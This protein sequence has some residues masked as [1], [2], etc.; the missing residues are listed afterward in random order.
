MATISIK[1]LIKKTNHVPVAVDAEGTTSV[2]V[3]G[4][5]IKDIGLLCHEHKDILK[6]L[7][8][9][10]PKEATDSKEAEPIDW[11]KMLDVSPEFCAEVIARGTGSKKEDAEALPTGIQIRL[12]IGIWGASAI[13]QEIVET[14]VK[15]IVDLLTKINHTIGLNS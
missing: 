12:L 15:K 13:D 10:E 7:I 11:G 9:P 4:L 8:S 1:D 2:E 6:K 3:R 5:S 14:A